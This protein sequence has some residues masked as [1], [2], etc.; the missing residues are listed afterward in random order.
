MMSFPA[1][2]Q[3]TLDRIEKT[4]LADDP[5]LGSLFANFTSLASPKAMPTTERVKP[6]QRQQLQVLAPF[7]L[8]TIFV[9]VV[10]CVGMFG[11]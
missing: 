3:R 7:V 1:R 8:I 6:R 9:V 4:L 11:W 5:R 2:Q 10:A